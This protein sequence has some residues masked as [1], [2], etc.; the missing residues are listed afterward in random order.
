MNSLSRLTVLWTLGCLTLAGLLVWVYSAPVFMQD[1]VSALSRMGFDSFS[2]LIEGG[3]KTDYHP[4]FVQVFLY[5]WTTLFGTSVFAVK[6]PSFL[7]GLGTVLLSYSIAKRIYAP[8][9]GLLVIVFMAFSQYYVMYFGLARPYAYGA[10][11]IALQL[12]ALIRWRQQPEQRVSMIALFI[13]ASVLAAWTHYFSLATAGLI[14]IW[15]FFWLASEERLKYLGACLGALILFSPH[16][17]VMIYHFSKEG[18]GGE[19]GWLNAPEPDFWWDY[20]RYLGQ[21]TFM[22]IAILIGSLLVGISRWRSYSRDQRHV[23][24]LGLGLMT[25]LMLLAYSYSVLRSPVFQFSILI[26]GSIPFLIA[27]FSGWS[28]SSKSITFAMLSV[29]LLSCLYGLFVEREHPDTIGYQPFDDLAQGVQAF[30]QTD[31]KPIVLSNMN[32]SF[33]QVYGDAMALEYDYVQV[34]DQSLEELRQILS[35]AGGVGI[36]QVNVPR[37]FAYMAMDQGYGALYQRP[38]YELWSTIEPQ[39][40]SSAEVPI[41][42]T[43][44]T[45]PYVFASGAQYSPEAVFSLEGI[46]GYPHLN[47]LLTQSLDEDTAQSLLVGVVKAGEKDLRWQG[48]KDEMETIAD[49][50]GSRISYLAIELAPFIDLET[51]SEISLQTYRWNPNGV[52]L[53]SG[54]IRL[55]IFKDTPTRYGL[56]QPF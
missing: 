49:D 35:S 43:L 19:S 46:E 11:F 48:S 24:G 47:I 41:L 9:S 45:L 30:N 2:A 13:L 27:V 22:G 8:A 44:L 14:G 31:V 12:Y 6:L 36:G 5:Y 20:L 17:S 38:T 21:Y 3:V 7:C 53:N 52:P 39:G 10:F 28:K 56:Y 55:R 4:A 32:P 1:E 25:V 40:S 15:G 54:P 33:M 42:D 18:I 51:E 23:F 34:A 29:T 50:K 16:L 37:T 26:F